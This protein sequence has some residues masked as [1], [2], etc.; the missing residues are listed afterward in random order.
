MIETRDGGREPTSVG[1]EVEED[2][3]SEKLYEV[4]VCL[5]SC[6]SVLFHVRVT[7]D[8]LQSCCWVP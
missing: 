7:R 8:I 4:R 6:V 5:G 1:D 3:I 2:D